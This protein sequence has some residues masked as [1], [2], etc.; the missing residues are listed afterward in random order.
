CYPSF[1]SCLRNNL[2]FTLMVFRIEHLMRYTCL[3]EL[4]TKHFIFL[5]RRGTNKY[6]LAGSMY[7]FYFRNHRLDLS[8][9]SLEDKIVSINTLYLTM[10]RHR[11]YIEL[12][13]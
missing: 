5:D 13:H 9:F 12:I 3:D 1:L 11:N 7:F 6:R 10:R 8:S 2:S 4:C